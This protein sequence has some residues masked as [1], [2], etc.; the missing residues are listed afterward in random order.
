MRVSL[1]KLLFNAR[2]K[3]REKIE[4]FLVSLFTLIIGENCD[5]IGPSICQAIG[6]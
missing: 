2:D 1:S 5:K 6:I 3:T 4:T